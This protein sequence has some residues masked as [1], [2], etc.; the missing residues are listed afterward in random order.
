MRS[1]ISQIEAEAGS[2]NLPVFP[3]GKW[4]LRL[5]P[6]VPGSGAW[7]AGLDP[8]GGPGRRGFSVWWA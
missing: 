1:S 8:W 7:V 3:A 4:E 2:F 5:D 6:V